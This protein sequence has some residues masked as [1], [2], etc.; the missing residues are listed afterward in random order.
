MMKKSSLVY[1]FKSQNI[2]LLSVTALF[3]I[4]QPYCEAVIKLPPGKV[5]PAVIG[6]GDSIIDTGN[7]N[8]LKSVVKCNFP[9]YGR[10]FNGGIPTGR[11]GNGL[12][13][14]D[15]IGTYFHY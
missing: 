1:L 11:F 2:Y 5:I 15:L 6:F 14:T 7:N 8:N 4:C 9:P 3:L 13:P 10:D 12:V